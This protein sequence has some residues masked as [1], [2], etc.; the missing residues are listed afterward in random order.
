MPLQVQTGMHKTNTSLL[1]LCG[2]GVALLDVGSGFIFHAG[3]RVRQ[4]AA[5]VIKRAIAVHRFNAIVH[6]A[7]FA[8]AIVVASCQ[9]YN[10][11]TNPKLFHN[12]ILVE[13]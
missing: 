7:A 2:E 9:C 13:T 1:T 10:K 6:G 5:I 11:N 12:A 3:G 8:F 4:R